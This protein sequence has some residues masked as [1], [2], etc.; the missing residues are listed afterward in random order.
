M[1]YRQLKPSNHCW[2]Y[3]NWNMTH[4]L[5]HWPITFAPFLFQRCQFHKI[6]SPHLQGCLKNSQN[7][8]QGHILPLPVKPSTYALPPVVAIHKGQA[9]NATVPKL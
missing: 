9:I 4:K 8:H 2:L 3:F 5:Y 1:H 7:L 6:P